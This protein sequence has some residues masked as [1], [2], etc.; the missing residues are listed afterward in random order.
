MFSHAP[1][2]IAC[3]AESIMA[4]T[5]RIVSFYA[6]AGYAQSLWP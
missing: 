3:S 1:P 6:P 5:V 2:P 4:D